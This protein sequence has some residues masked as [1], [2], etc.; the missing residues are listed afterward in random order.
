MGTEDRPC[1]KPVK[2]RV[3]CPV[4][5]GVYAQAKTGRVGRHHG[6]PEVGRIHAEHL[7][8]PAAAGEGR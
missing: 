6:T 8:A 3:E 1:P 2:R 4:C 7:A 5:H